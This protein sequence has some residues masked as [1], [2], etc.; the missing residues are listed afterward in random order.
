MGNKTVKNILVIICLTHM[1]STL[2]ALDLDTLLQEYQSESDLSLK[3]RKENAGHVIIFTRDD[4]ERMQVESLK[5]V[6]KA[7]PFFRYMENRTARPDMLNADPVL[8]QSKSIRVYINDNEML[9]PTMGSGFILFGNIDMDF[10]DHVEIYEGFPTFEFG[11]E[12]STVAIRLYTKDA[13]HDSGSRIK[14]LVASHATNKANVYTAGTTESGFSYYLYANHTQNNQ[15]TYSLESKDVKRNIQTKHFYASIKKENYKI[16][17]QALEQK[18]DAFLGHL[19][20]AVPQ[21]T[22]I[23]EKFLNLAFS[24][25]FLEDKSLQLNF[26]YIHTREHYNA[27]YNPR[28]SPLFGGFEKE[29]NSANADALT[30]VL[31]KKFSLK[32]HTISVGFQG[33]YKSFDMNDIQYD[34]ASAPYKQMYDKEYAYSIFAQDSILLSEKNLFGISL[35]QQYYNRNRNVRSDSLTQA[36]LAYIYS[37]NKFTSKTFLIRQNFVPEAYQMAIPRTGNP[38]LKSEIYKSVIEELHYRKQNILSKLILGYVTTQRVQLPNAQ[39]IVQNSTGKLKN[40]YIALEFDYNF[41]LKDKLL[42]KADY[43][44]SDFSQFVAGKNFSNEYFSYLIRML[45]SFGKFDIF[46]ELVINQG[47]QNVKVGY[48]YSAGVRYGVNKDFHINLKG[49]NI[50]NRGLTRKYYYNLVPVA[51]QIEVPVEEQKVMLSLEY[52]F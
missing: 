36:R 2:F 14:A 8:Y 41:R 9:I 23:K 18:K 6:L 19:P 49:E 50:F 25:L 43:T 1:I 37:T 22:Q 12:P 31:Q 21:S 7:L 44:K 26:S 10:I 17:L 33:R 15:K 38:H 30:L 28:L 32:N 24:N 34:G 35:M 40:R 48:D 5:D 29:E 20:Y 45:N 51:K 52:L 3:T 39:G 13:R 27:L 47:Y 4:L 16:E 42:L 11:I 46:N